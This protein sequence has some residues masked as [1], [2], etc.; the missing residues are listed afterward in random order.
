MRWWK[1]VGLAGVA[2]VVA[3][4]VVVVRAERRRRAYTPDQ[5]REQLHA[6]FAE[7]ASAVDETG[8]A[9]PQPVPGLGERVRR[10]FLRWS[11]REK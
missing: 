7:A 3:T 9:R 6:R 10:L 4:G 5:V 1:A 2:G 8:D 11:R